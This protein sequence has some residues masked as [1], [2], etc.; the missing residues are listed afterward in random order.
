MVSGGRHFDQA[1]R[2]EGKLLL[3]GRSYDVDG[4]TVRDRSWGE[5]RT[6]DPRELPPVHWL[7]GVFDDDFAFHL[8]G[9]EH[10]GSDPVWRELYPVDDAF[11][12]RMNRGWVWTGGELRGL[13]R[14]SV[15]THWDPTTCYPLRHDVALTDSAGREY[16][17]TGTV[18]AENNWSAWSNAFFGIGLARW[19]HEGR[20]GWGDSQIGAWTDFVHALHTRR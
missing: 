1:M 3:R 16:E 20:T 9:I 10:P 4:Y 13:E 7:T 5:N 17:F 2:T 15:R 19:E 12:D 8:T 6:E 11:A 14:A 18:V